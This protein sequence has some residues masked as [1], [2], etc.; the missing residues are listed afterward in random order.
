MCTQRARFTFA[1]LKP[2][3][4]YGFYAHVPIDIET[5]IQPKRCRKK[6]LTLIDAKR[7]IKDLDMLKLYSS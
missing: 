3:S 1:L 2:V 4:F 6:R 5:N 7:R